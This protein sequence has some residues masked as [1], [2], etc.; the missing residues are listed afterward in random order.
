MRGRHPSRLGGFAASHLDEELGGGEEP[1]PEG[2]EELEPD[3]PDEPE[4]EPDEP[5]PDQLEY[6]WDVDEPEPEPEGVGPG[7]GPAELDASPT[8]H[9]KAFTAAAGGEGVSACAVV[10]PRLG[11]AGDFI[12]VLRKVRSDSIGKGSLQNRPCQAAGSSQ[13]MGPHTAVLYLAAHG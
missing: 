2:G 9:E 3:E 1:E 7:P 11:L 4:P 10:F 13:E 6:E 8:G 12:A 5:E